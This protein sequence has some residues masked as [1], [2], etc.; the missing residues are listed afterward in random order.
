MLL[1]RMVWVSFCKRGN[2]LFLVN[3]MNDIFMAPHLIDMFSLSLNDLCFQS[4]SL[5]ACQFQVSLTHMVL[6]FFFISL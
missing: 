1:E 6:L 3:G 4:T 2:V 5:L